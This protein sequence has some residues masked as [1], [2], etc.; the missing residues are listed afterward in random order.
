MRFNFDIN[1]RAD[2]CSSAKR[3]RSVASLQLEEI[4]LEDHS[5]S[6]AELVRV[7][8]TLVLFLSNGWV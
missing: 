8:Q 1:C 6:L 3:K 4:K 2:S 5:C 7:R